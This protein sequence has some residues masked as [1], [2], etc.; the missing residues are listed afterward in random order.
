MDLESHL[1]KIEQNWY[2]HDGQCSECPKWHTGGF[3]RPFFG[4]SYQDPEEAFDAEVVFVGEE[5]GT[6]GEQAHEEWREEKQISLSE[7]ID[8]ITQT[9]WNLGEYPRPSSGALNNDELLKIVTGEEPLS[10]GSNDTEFTYYITNLE[11][12]HEPYDEPDDKDEYDEESY[13][14]DEVYHTEYDQKESATNC[15]FPYLKREIEIIE[16]Q[17]VVTLGASARNGVS[18]RFSGFGGQP[19]L[20][21]WP[22]KVLESSS[23]SVNW[24]LIPLLHPSRQNRHYKHFSKALPDDKGPKNDETKAQKIYFDMARQIIL[25]QIEA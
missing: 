9:E 3:K 2:N 24:K 18:N 20:I 6:E 14:G 25:E 21:Q 8:M 15:C 16:P 10:G 4:A 23:E 5:P 12:C 11:K 1:H 17:V 13:L 19:K 22:P 7:G